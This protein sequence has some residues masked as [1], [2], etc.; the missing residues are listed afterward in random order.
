MRIDL[1]PASVSAVREAAQGTTSIKQ[2]P[3]AV[4]VSIRKSAPAPE[5]NQLN[6]ALDDRHNVIYRFTDP[7][8]GKLVR[9]IPPEE[10][11]RIM[12]N[13]ED[14]LQEPEPK[15]KVAL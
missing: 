6:V 5:P 7:E 12:R 1:S 11:L 9:Q 8:S 4:H 2:A 10:I 15:L 13:I 14:L 3:A